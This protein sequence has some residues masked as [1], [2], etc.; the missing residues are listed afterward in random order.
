[1]N[2]NENIGNKGKIVEI[3]KGCAYKLSYT[4]VAHYSRVSNV[5][6]NKGLGTYFDLRNK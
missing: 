2:I 4:S 6:P 5:V 3:N 1:M